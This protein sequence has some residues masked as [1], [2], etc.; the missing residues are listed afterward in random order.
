ML[1]PF[2]Y[3]INNVGKWSLEIEHSITLILQMGKLDLERKWGAQGH[4]DN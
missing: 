4:T 2:R 3:E 1:F